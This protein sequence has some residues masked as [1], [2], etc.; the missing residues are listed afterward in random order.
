[1]FPACCVFAYLWEPLAHVYVGVTQGCQSIMTTLCGSD[2]SRNRLYPSL[3]LSSSFGV[4]VSFSLCVCRV[5]S[6][7]LHGGTLSKVI[8]CLCLVALLWF[9]LWVSQAERVQLYSTCHRPGLEA[10]SI[11]S[12]PFPGKHSIAVQHSVSVH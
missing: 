8:L 1:M 4:S 9:I 6:S 7:R 2:R 10:A 5:G 3:I 12:S 11:L